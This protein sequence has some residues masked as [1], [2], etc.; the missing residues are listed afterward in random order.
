[1]PRCEDCGKAIGFVRFCPECGTRTKLDQH[2][3]IDHERFESLGSA[4]TET[5]ATGR[6]R[7]R[8]RDALRKKTLF[9][10][11]P[12][13]CLIVAMFAGA[14][15]RLAQQPPT[16]PEDAMVV[17]AASPIVV[18]KTAP[19][20]TAPPPTPTP[21]PTATPSPAP[22]RTRPTTITPSPL[23]SAALS[24]DDAPALV[25]SNATLTAGKKGSCGNA[26]VT[27][28]VRGFPRGCTL[29]GLASSGPL[30]N[31][32]G[33]A[34]VVPV[35]TTEDIEDVAYGLLY[36]RSDP[37]ATPRFVGVLAG[38]GSSSVVMYLQNGL[39]VEQSGAHKTS[40]TFNGRRIVRIHG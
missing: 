12:A 28:D 11:M 14:L 21:V 24:S 35:S 18:R 13:A 1:M 8:W 34:L 32:K 16:E 4:I 26:N 3:L 40:F 30:A 5:Y 22:T 38:N 23:A 37:A 19:P 6:V 27:I 33:T 10:L 20:P 15:Q 39:I 2:A 17:V 9:W 36:I 25:R 31:G 7:A 29:F